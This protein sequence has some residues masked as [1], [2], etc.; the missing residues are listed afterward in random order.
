MID[1]RLEI[2]RIVKDAKRNTVRDIR[3]ILDDMIND[4]EPTEPMYTGGLTPI[5]VR[6]K[7]NEKNN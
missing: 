1:V 5:R 6:K 4:P 2:N 7:R 3:K